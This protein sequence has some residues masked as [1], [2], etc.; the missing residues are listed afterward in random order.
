MGAFWDWITAKDVEEEIDRK[1]AERFRDEPRS[2]DGVW[3]SKKHEA[4]WCTYP[5]CGCGRLVR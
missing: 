5:N 2:P 1:V 4:N 3:C